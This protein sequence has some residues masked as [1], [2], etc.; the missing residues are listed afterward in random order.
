LLIELPRPQ[1][2]GPLADL[3]RDIEHE[4][5][6]AAACRTALET[7]EDELAEAVEKLRELA[8]TELC[9]TCGAP[10][11]ADRLLA[12]VD[13]GHGGHQHG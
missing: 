2:V 4:L 11:D 8:E 12:A 7:A 3:L 9:P 1:D 13:A 10:L 5:A 6:R